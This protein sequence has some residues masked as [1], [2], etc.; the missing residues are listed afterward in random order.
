MA[1]TIGFDTVQEYLSRFAALG[2]IGASPHKAF[3][4]SKIVSG[5][6]VPITYSEFVNGTVPNVTYRGSPIPIVWKDFPLLSPLF[7][8][9]AESAGYGGIDQM[10]PG[11]PHL[12]DPGMTITLSS[13]TTVT[14]AKVLDDLG[15]WLQNGLPEHPAPIP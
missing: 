14:G 4:K 10:I 13:G 3:W 6:P 11:G 9:L 2:T 12:T 1:V 7:L 5:V 8:I 15:V